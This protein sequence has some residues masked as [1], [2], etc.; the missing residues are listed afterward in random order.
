[1]RGKWGLKAKAWS[2]LEEKWGLGDGQVLGGTESPVGRL[3]GAQK[4]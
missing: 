2:R 3:L 4:A 1:M